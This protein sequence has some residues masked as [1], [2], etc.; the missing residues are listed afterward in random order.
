MGVAICSRWRN[1]TPIIILPAAI[2]SLVIGEEM[3]FALQL[4]NS[5]NITRL[6]SLR[7]KLQELALPN[8]VRTSSLESIL[9]KFIRYIA[10]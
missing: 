3:A 10:Y 8:T 5:Y 1:A 9:H 2:V 6:R 7:S 4:S